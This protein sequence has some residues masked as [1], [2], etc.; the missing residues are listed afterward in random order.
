[1]VQTG[2][3]LPDWDWNRY[4]LGWSGPIEPAQSFRMVIFGPWLVAAWRIAGVAASLAL[5][6]LLL[7]PHVG[8]VRRLLSSGTGTA[9]ALA[10]AVLLM[11]RDGPAQATSEFPSPELL[12][13][14]RSRLT[15][16]EP[17]HPDCA[18]ITR[19]AVRLGES[20]L[21]V[22]LIVAVQGAVAVPMPGSADGWRADAVVVNGEPASQLYRGPRETSWARLEEGVHD[23]VLRG[24]VPADNSFA[25]FFPLVPR[26][27]EVETPGW[28]AAGIVDGRLLSGALELV[29]R[30]ERDG[31]DEDG[32]PATSFPPYV[33]VVR[34]VTLGLNWSART[35]VERTA[36][37]DG[38]FTLPVDLLPGEVVLT[39]R[40]RN[41]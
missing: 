10:L 11:P 35:E 26:H 36:P 1:M 15:A 24:P 20:T 2:P 7:R 25:L 19:A 18:E 22:D 30:V 14:L 37:A 13:E 33:R 27:I 32:A 34:T 5:L 17:C 9:A 23:V 38:A 29:R 3:G 40:H 31:A 28:D 41:Q 39:P 16:P 4:S 21:S 8:A 6:Y 12:Q